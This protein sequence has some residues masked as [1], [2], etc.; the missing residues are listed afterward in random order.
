MAGPYSQTE[1]HG[2]SRSP[3]YGLMAQPWPRRA[4]RRA[5]TRDRAPLLSAINQAA[6]GA[7]PPS[8]RP[9]EAQAQQSRSAIFLGAQ[10]AVAIAPQGSATPPAAA[11]ATPAAPSFLPGKF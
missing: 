11:Q 7:I 5:A 2:C 4:S 1:G 9:L 8:Q 6:P 10:P 3:A